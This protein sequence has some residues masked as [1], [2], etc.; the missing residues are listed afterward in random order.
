LIAIVGTG[1]VGVESSGVVAGRW[2]PAAAV[3]DSTVGIVQAV[4]RVGLSGAVIVCSMEVGRCIVGACTVGEILPDAAIVDTTVGIVQAGRL[5]G[6][7][8]TVISCSMKIAGC[9][10]VAIASS[11]IGTGVGACVGAVLGTGCFFNGGSGSIGDNPGPA[12]T[13]GDST[14]GIIQAVSCGGL[15]GAVISVTM[16]V[17]SCGVLTVRNNPAAS[18][19]DSTIGI[20]QAVS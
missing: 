9:V 15:I 5:G 16:L 4:S 2:C 3:V 12:A 19:G 18:I 20:I 13:V 1:G 10:I 14:I 7:I 8:E 11:S 17:V 6:L